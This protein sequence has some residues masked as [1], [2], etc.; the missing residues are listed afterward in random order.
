MIKNLILALVLM[1]SF[2]SC[3][4]Y[5]YYVGDGPQTGIKVTKKNHYFINGLAPGG[6]SDPTV[7]AGDA[8]DYEVTITHSF[9]DGLIS[10]LT[11]GIYSPTT[12]IVTNSGRNLETVFLRFLS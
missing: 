11:F 2:S 9:V 10:A 7:M 3:Y 5:S 12:T 1:V 4:T 6:T 8:E